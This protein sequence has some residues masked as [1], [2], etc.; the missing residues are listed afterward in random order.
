MR[1]FLVVRL[2]AEE[3]YS[4]GALVDADNYAHAAE[5]AL[6]APAD[7]VTGILVAPA[8]LAHGYR[9]VDG[10]AVR[11]MDELVPEGSTP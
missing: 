2:Y 6:D 8:G 9:V 4:D 10:A 3:G 7:A 5:L 1:A 11:T